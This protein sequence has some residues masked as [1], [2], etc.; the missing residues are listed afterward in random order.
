[1]T[2]QIDTIKSLLVLLNKEK[3]IKIPDWINNL[4]LDNLKTI[5]KREEYFLEPIEVILKTETISKSRKVVILKDV[6]HY[7]RIFQ[8][9]SSVLRSDP[10]S[11]K[12]LIN[13]K[14]EILSSSSQLNNLIILIIFL[15][16]YK[17]GI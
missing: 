10:N 12:K 7:C 5:I 4:T 3:I 14:N 17:Y 13:D 8:T 6:M 2:L 15:N 1:M 9:V 11:L 16:Y